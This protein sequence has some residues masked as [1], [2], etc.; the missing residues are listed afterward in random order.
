VRPFSSFYTPARLIVVHRAAS[1]SDSVVSVTSHAVVQAPQNMS[2]SQNNSSSRTNGVASN[3][4]NKRARPSANSNNRVA[5]PQPNDQYH[6]HDPILPP[7]GYNGI[8][9]N[10]RRDAFNVPPSS[11]HPSLPNP[12]QGAGSSNIANGTHLVPVP[13][14]IHA[15]PQS[16]INPPEWNPPPTQL[17]GP[18]MPLARSQ[19]IQPILPLIST[20]VIPPP[21]GEMVEP[22]EGEGDG[23][24]N[25]TYCFCERVSYGEM[26]ACDDTQCEREWVCLFSLYL[27]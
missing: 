26:I 8:S 3:A 7:P 16:L 23:D 27:K 17:E 13:Y 5:T 1:P 6:L 22:A 19:L 25:K 2:R 12:Y 21:G 15:L 4:T 9:A 11:L 18:G 14:D 10:S 20:P 24:D